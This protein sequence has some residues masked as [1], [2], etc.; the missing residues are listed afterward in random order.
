MIL[1]LMIGKRGQATLFIILGIVLV[2]I[3]VLLFA[4][5]TIELPRRFVESSQTSN[6]D[7]YIEQCVKEVV[8][9]DLTNR[10]GFGGFDSL[11]DHRIVGRDNKEY[12]L[13]YDAKIPMNYILTKTGIQNEV[14]S[15]VDNYLRTY[16]DLSRFGDVRYNQLGVSSLIDDYDV[17]VNVVLPITLTKGGVEKD[18]Y[19]INLK[20]D[21]GK[22]WKVSYDVVEAVANGNSVNYYLG[23]DFQLLVD[24]GWNGNEQIYTVKRVDEEKAMRFA[25]RTDIL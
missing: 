21:F 19:V 17:I 4:T 12:N 1:N 11:T 22:F 8:E 25:V 10:I 7:T 6:I 20:S 23:G 14:S 24:A 15:K 13:I 2:I 5:R 16:C 3:V 9:E 18:K